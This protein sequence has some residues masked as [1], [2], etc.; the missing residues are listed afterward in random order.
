MSKQR[1]CLLINILELYYSLC[2]YTHT[3]KRTGHT[4]GETYTLKIVKGRKQ[5]SMA[6]KQR[7]NSVVRGYFRGLDPENGKE[8]TGRGTTLKLGSEQQAGNDLV[9]L[10]KPPNLKEKALRCIPKARTKKKKI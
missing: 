8:L 4:S 6:S 3:A 7:C 9:R 2:S 10:V 5:V 1:E